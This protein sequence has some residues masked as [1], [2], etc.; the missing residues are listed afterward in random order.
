MP[1]RINIEDIQQD[2]YQVMRKYFNEHPEIDH[3]FA[4][5][6][7]EEE[8]TIFIVKYHTFL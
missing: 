5:S 2:I 6:K 1:E 4:K 3:L 8:L 7:T